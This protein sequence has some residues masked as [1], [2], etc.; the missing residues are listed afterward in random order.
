MPRGCRRPAHAR[1]RFL[2]TRMTEFLD[3]LERSSAQRTRRIGTDRPTRHQG[4]R[5]RTLQIHV[6]D[7]NGL[8]AAPQRVSGA[9]HAMVMRADCAA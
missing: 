3:R 4:R 6:P 5:D 9:F 1:S 7:P 8:R 2:H